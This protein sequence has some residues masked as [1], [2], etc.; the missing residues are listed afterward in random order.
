V[1]ESTRLRSVDMLRGVAIL[2]VLAIHIPHG[3]PGGW[4]ENPWLLP[5]FLADFGYLGVPLFIVISGFC[6]HRNAAVARAGGAGYSFDWVAFWKRRFIRL[7]PPYLA[8]IA[9]SLAAAFW[10]HHHFPD[11][12][13]FLGWDL[14]THLL[15][16]HNLTAEFATSLGNGAFWSLGTEE[17]LYALYFVLIVLMARSA[18]SWWLAGVAAITVAWRLLTPFFPATGADLG[19]FHLGQWFQWPLHYWL[20]WTLGAIAVD[21]WMGNRE[22]PAWAGS[23]VVAIAGLALGI[24]VNSNTFEFLSKLSFAHGWLQGVSPAL[25]AAASNLG[26]LSVLLGFFCLLN[27]SLR[28]PPSPAILDLPADAFAWIGRIS[29][30]L[31]LVHIPVIFV[32]E[33]R[34]PF[35]YSVPSWPW[36]YLAYGSISIAT[37]W[38]FHQTVERWFLK[39]RLPHFPQR[40]AMPERA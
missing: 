5:S 17:Q 1:A 11:P 25:L 34:L 21:A 37:A 29:Y 20:H 31:Y 38:I 13:R 7:Y 16:V 3:A 19:P 10:W 36:R 35:A 4:R 27:W 6:I 32:L 12:G 40:A 2:L 26:E 30:S 18:S 23:L 39:G 24:V 28:A 8:A 15:L 33:E 9:L 14:G 22:L